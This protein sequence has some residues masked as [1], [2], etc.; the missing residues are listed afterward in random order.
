M[1]FEDIVNNIEQIKIQRKD[2]INNFE[3]KYEY[4][5]ESLIQAVDN[6][7]LNT[8]RVHK[9]LTENKKIGKVKTARFLEDIGLNEKTKI[10]ELNNTLIEQIANYS[11][12]E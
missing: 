8:I 12:R 10:Y 2:F 9:Y 7:Y 3:N 6:N 1:K 11:D 4:A 5:H